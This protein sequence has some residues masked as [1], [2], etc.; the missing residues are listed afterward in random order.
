MTLTRINRIEWLRRFLN[1]VFIE[2]GIYEANGL[3]AAVDAGFETCMTCDTELLHV[4]A[5]K[6]RLPAAIVRHGPSTRELPD[7]IKRAGGRLITFWL[8]AHSDFASPLLQELGLIRAYA[9]GN[10][11]ILIDDVR[12]FPRYGFTLSDV[13]ASLLRVNPSYEIQLHPGHVPGDVIAAVPP[14]P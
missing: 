7:M 5:A 3:Q 8:D 13:V 11:T 10:H 4:E 1:P 12:C 6:K 9:G 2:T 14:K